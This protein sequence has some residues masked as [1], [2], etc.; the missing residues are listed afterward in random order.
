MGGCQDFP[1]ISIITP[2]LNDEKFISQ[3]IESVL[4]QEYPNLEYIVIDCGSID[5]SLDIVNAYKKDIVLEHIPTEDRFNAI[6]QVLSKTSGQVIGFL[7]PKAR[8]FDGSLFVVGE[9]FK[10]CQDISWITSKAFVC[11]DEYNQVNNLIESFP[12]YFN[13]EKNKKIG[14]EFS[15][16]RRDLINDLKL[17]DNVYLKA[18]D[19]WSLFLKKTKLYIIESILGGRYI[20]SKKKTI[21]ETSR[22]ERWLDTESFVLQYAQFNFNL[23]Y[24]RISFLPLSE[25]VDRSNFKPIFRCLSRLSSEITDAIRS[26]TS[27]VIRSRI[28]EKQKQLLYSMLKECEIH[29]DKRSNYLISTIV[30]SYKGEEF[31]KECLDDLLSQTLKDKIQIIIIDA[32]SP[33]NEGD[34]IR[35]YQKKYLNICYVRTPV[36]IGVYTAWN[37]GILLAKGSLITPFSTNDRLRKDAY[38]LLAKELLSNPHVAL[39]YGDTKVTDEPHQDFENASP[40]KTHPNNFVWPDFSYFDL[41]QR[42]LVGPHPMWKTCIHDRIGFFD[43]F[44]TAMA[45]QEFWLRVGEEFELKHIPLFTGLYWLDEDALS[46]HAKSSL[47]IYEKEHIRSMYRNRNFLYKQNK[48]FQTKI[49]I[50]IPV[51]NQVEYTRRCLYILSYVLKKFLN[52]EVIV[53]DNASSDETSNFLKQVSGN[54]KVITNKE[55]LGYTLACNQGA[56]EASGE[57]LLFLNN[58]TEPF[59]GFLEHMLKVFERECNVGAVGCQLIYPNGTIQEAGAVV[60]S[61]GTALNFGRGKDPMLSIFNR[62]S[63]VDYCSGACLL[64]PKEIFKEVGGFDPIYSPGYYEDTDYSFTL[65]SLGLETYYEPNA[66]ILHHGSVSAGLDENQGMRRFLSINRKKFLKK[67]S[68]ALRKHE[69]RPEDLDCVWTVD[70]DFLGFRVAN[71]YIKRKYHHFSF[72]CSAENKLVTDNFQ[73]KFKMEKKSFFH[74]YKDTDICFVSDFMPRFDCSS[75][76]LRV[77]NILKICTSLGYKLNYF[78]FIPDEN[79]QCYADLHKNVT[80]KLIDFNSKRYLEYILD[81]N[82]KVLWV[83]NLWLLEY[84]QKVRFIVKEIRKHGQDIKIIIDTMD[85]H[86]KKFLRKYR[87]SKDISDLYVAEQFLKLEQETYPFADQLIVVT[88]Q[89]KK[90]L[91]QEL[92][93]LPPITV[94]PNIHYFSNINIP[95]AKRKGIV[96]L[97]NFDVNHNYDAVLYFL[98][99]IYPRI[100]ELNDNIKFH[101]VGFKSREKFKHLENE[102]V[103]VHGKVKDLQSFLQ[104]FRVFV[105]PLTYG[106]GMKGKIGEAIVSGL[107]IVSTAIG[108]E[109]FDLRDKVDCFVA[110]SPDDF[111]LKTSL[112]YSKQDIWEN[113]VKKSREKLEEKINLDKIKTNI[114]KLLS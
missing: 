61:D 112:L 47:P 40:S 79:D 15:F 99:E 97:G 81:S 19:L 96:F 13:I 67:W 53:I 69:D 98:K 32:D 30:S 106:A 62:V 78:Y 48:L 82:P 3:C 88:E 2:C 36:R 94:I 38:E 8:Y 25:L 24:K 72:F 16:W 108:I 100:L 42:C 107:P 26:A 110:D 76:Q 77:H 37:L 64:T 33:Q 14:V 95:F 31:I 74:S 41:L 91:E 22:L 85:F 102:N 49:S 43:E 5:S 66:K 17:T 52:C 86:A 92:I 109:G 45:D 111:A 114:N 80:F 21:L 50:I 58:D 34:I 63:R 65:R 101:I 55:N 7:Y 59:S 1:R 29:F 87:L 103:I 35:E 39:V 10:S 11:W 68:I 23:N 4:S 56:E 12:N 28:I 57:F 75:S 113:F 70:R 84:F 44:Y 46:N 105:C 60:F 18:D 83:T 90:D 54:F 71:N 89:E 27:Q 104:Q 9:I 73:K 20:K 51:Y 6:R 93:N